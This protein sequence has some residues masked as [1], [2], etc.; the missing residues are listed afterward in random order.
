MA[1]FIR[2]YAL[3]TAAEFKCLG[4]VSAW[5]ELEIGTIVR[6]NSRASAKLKFTDDMKLLFGHLSY[7]GPVSHEEVYRKV[8]TIG[9]NYYLYN[10]GK[11]ERKVYLQVR[12]ICQSFRLG[13]LELLCFF[14]NTNSV[15]VLSCLLLRATWSNSILR[16]GL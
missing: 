5:R 13:V 15:L 2:P 14:L 10:K 8:T 7:T 1:N 9:V 11:K 16:W 12:R 6:L 3:P 4:G